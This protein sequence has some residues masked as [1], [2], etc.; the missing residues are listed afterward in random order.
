MGRYRQDRT[1]LRQQEHAQIHLIFHQRSMENLFPRRSSCLR[2]TIALFEIYTLELH[3]LR[4]GR[5]NCKHQ[6][7]DRFNLNSKMCLQT[8]KVIS[9]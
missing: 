2:D 9:S 8:W 1:F 3:S 4:C 5:A 7:N 6:T